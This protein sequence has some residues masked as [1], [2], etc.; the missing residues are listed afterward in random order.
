MMTR[1]LN[2]MQEF[3]DI[4]GVCP[5]C[6]DIRGEAK[7]NPNALPPGTVLNGRY[8]V[9]NNNFS[10]DTFKYYIGYDLFMYRKCII[11]EL[12]LQDFASREG[13]YSV[14]TEDEKIYFDQCM[15]NF[16]KCAENLALFQTSPYVNRIYDHFPENG[17]YYQ[18]TEQLDH[19]RWFSLR[20]LLKRKKRMAPQEAV[21]IIL[22]VIAGMKEIHDKGFLHLNITPDEVMLTV[23]GDLR[24][25][26]SENAVKM[27]VKRNYKPVLITPGY[28]AR[29]VYDTTN[30]YL[31][32]RTDVYSVAAL[33][34]RILT[35]RLAADSIAR[36]CGDELIRPSEMGIIL[37]GNMEKALLHA[38]E[39]GWKKRTQT[40]EQFEAELKS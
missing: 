31:G 34:Y 12:F 32:P 23:D 11:K 27:P 36:Q 24:I 13:L 1:C 10:T 4:Y 29:E 6:G 30:K 33:L 15:T 18:I 14:V 35:G 17:T 3:D 21:P 40:M 26:S 2:C 19:S 22:K 28:T 25:Y 9:G 16:R 20:Q 7:I 38:L 8:L 5:H 39:V 37:P